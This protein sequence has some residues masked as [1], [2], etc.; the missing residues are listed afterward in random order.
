MKFQSRTTQVS[1]LGAILAIMASCSTTPPVE[2]FAAGANPA[3][4][5]QKLESEMTAAADSQ[6]DVFSPENY[7]DAREALKDAQEDLKDK[8]DAEDILE[9]VAKSRAYFKRA[10]EFGKVAADTMPDVAAA[11]ALALKTGAKESISKDFR[12]VDEELKGVADNIEKN[13][14]DKATKKRQELQGKYLDLELRGIKR[15]YISATE[16]NIRDAER[17]N[18]DD[19]APRTLAKAKKSY[20]DAEASINANRHDDAA[21]KPLADKATADAALLRKITDQVATGNFT[22][23]SALQLH[24]ANLSTAEKSAALASTEAQLSKT[25][26]AAA[27]AQSSLDA[28]KAIDAK[29]EQA[30]GMFSNNEAEVYR[31]GKNIVIRLRALEFDTAKAQL[32]GASFPLLSKVNDVIA[33]FPQSTVTIEGHTDSKGGKEINAKVSQARADAVKAY[34]E[35]NSKAQGAKYSAVGMDFQKPLASNKTETGRAQNRRVDVVI[36][37]DNM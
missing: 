37:P 23:E 8:D 33:E 4:E 26:A 32:K 12:D 17:N 2:N 9:E 36:V 10:V 1:M 27:T 3:E 25:T 34:F 19:R 13:D 11:R 16:G 35:S 14:L 5:I 22:E 20:Q 7:K 15:N 6:L 28:Q 18:A 31:Q 24:A 29:Y 30:R 21:I